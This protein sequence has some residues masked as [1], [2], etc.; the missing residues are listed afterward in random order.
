[1][2]KGCNMNVLSSKIG[3]NKKENAEFLQ[4]ASISFLVILISFLLFYLNLVPTWLTNDDV[5]MSMRTHGYGS[6]IDKELPVLIFSSPIW[7]WL[8]KHIPA[9][10]GV[11]GYTWGAIFTLFFTSWFLLFCL[12]RNGHG[13]IFSCCL[14]ILIYALPM[15]SPQFTLNSG[16]ACMAAFL[17]I[18]S[19]ENEKRKIYLVLFLLFSFVGYL[20]RAN[21]FLFVVAV[22]AVLFPWRLLVKDK[23]LLITCSVLIFSLSAFYMIAVTSMSSDKWKG[24]KDLKYYR[25][26]FTDYHVGNNLAEQQELLD[27]HGYSTNDLELLKRFFFVDPTLADP[28]RLKYLLKDVNK[29]PISFSNIKEGLN[30]IGKILGNDKIRIFVVLGL[31]LAI[32]LLQKRLLLAYFILF[33]LICFFGIAGRSG[34]FR[35]YYSTFCLLAVLPL[36]F[37]NRE[38]VNVYL[39]RCSFAILLFGIITGYQ[40]I[41]QKSRLNELRIKNYISE[42]KKLP[43]I[44]TPYVWGGGF[45]MN[46]CFIFFKMICKYSTNLSFI[47][48]RVIP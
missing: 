4:V 44:E 37:C 20:I 18:V 19:Y 30:N 42:F 41:I 14:I 25:I 33:G 7:G 13:F 31:L 47:R 24:F 34:Q 39:K 15:I 10:G 12:L 22:T 38:E 40:G 3:I 45:L 1:M 23:Q 21:E 35:V 9:V 29:N 5:G 27:L 11:W 36:I 32:G 2:Q 8:V 26:L 17:S 46:M 16:L 48:S 6:F 43:M 28:D